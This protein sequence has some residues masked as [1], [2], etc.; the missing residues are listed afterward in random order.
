MKPS[1]S[2]NS[3][4]STSNLNKI[5]NTLKKDKNV[6]KY[7]VSSDSKKIAVIKMTKN[8]N[9][10]GSTGEFDIIN[11]DDNK[12]NI[13]PEIQ[14]D[15]MHMQEATWSY[16]NQYLAIENGTA[17]QHGV[18]IVDASSYK[19]VLDE[20][21]CTEFVWKSDANSFVYATVDK[22]VP[23][24]TP[25]ELDGSPELLT[26]DL[27]TKKTEVILKADPK[28]LYYPVKWDKWGIQIRICKLSVE[29]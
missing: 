22:S 11:V 13:V 7:V 10:S 2:A 27:D 4:V 9:A 20:S 29:Q 3:K 28:N 23:Q 8:V 5:V 26:Y 16:N 17:A 14:Y 6:K 24:I 21:L 12:T 1:S 15:D 18:T 25:T 19:M